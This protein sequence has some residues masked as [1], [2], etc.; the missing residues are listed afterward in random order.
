MNTDKLIKSYVKDSGAFIQVD[1][2]ED[3]EGNVYREMTDQDGG[4]WIEEGE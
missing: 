1:V 2:Y 4:S 3:E